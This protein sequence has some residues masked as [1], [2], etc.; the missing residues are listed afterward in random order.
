[1]WK[2]FEPTWNHSSVK[3]REITVTVQSSVKG[4]N[5]RAF[6]TEHEN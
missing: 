4:D 6:I 3:K 5:S 1:M 2:F